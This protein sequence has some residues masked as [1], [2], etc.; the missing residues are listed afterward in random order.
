MTSGPLLRFA[1]ATVGYHRGAVVSGAS[2]VVAP[3]EVVGLVG[4]NGAGKS[5]LLRTVTDEARVF[6]GSVEL[7]GRPLGSYSPADRAAVVG[8]VP[9]QTVA[10][11]GFRAV[12]FVAL[13][14]HP[15]VARFAAFTDRDESIVADAMARTDTAH[16]AEKVTSELSGGDLQRLALA[17]ALAQEPQVLLLDEPTSHLDLNHRLQILD[18]MQE[19]A[20]GGLGVLAVFHDLDLAARYAD[21]LAVVHDGRVEPAL[22]PAAVLTPATLRRVFGVRAVVGSDPVTGSVTVSPVVRDAAIAAATSG[23]V[24]VIGGS[25]MAAPLMR[26]LV[27]G[28]WTVTAG[29]LNGGDADAEIARALGIHYIEL[30]PFAPMDPTAEESVRHLAG[31]AD[32]V[33][34]CEVPFGHGN[35]G[36]LRAAVESHSPAV[37]LGR[38]EERDFT[39]GEAGRWWRRALESGATV[40]ESGEDPL[41]VLERFGAGL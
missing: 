39:D 6:S 13:G 23:R 19:L 17:Q 15:H 8:V 31:E 35:V 5:T 18:L 10:A 12:D 3:G 4:P 11:F 1:E 7:L 33:L 37:L 30:P 14:R 16:L 26:R 29:A 28:G 21:R 40:V 34:V 22:P 41:P 20:Q 9:Q 25:G 2:L 27:I 38:I 24:L 36:N 32:V